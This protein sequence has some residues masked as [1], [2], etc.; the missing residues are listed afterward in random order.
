MRASRA[1]TSLTRYPASIVPSAKIIDAVTIVS[2][3]PQPM[4]SA[5]REQTHR[6]RDGQADDSSSRS[7]SAFHPH[8]QKQGAK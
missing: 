7:S 6:T 2:E 3:R 4:I 5:S 8:S 1:F